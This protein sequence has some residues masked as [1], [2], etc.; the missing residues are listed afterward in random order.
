E[1][2]PLAVGRTMGCSDL[3]ADLSA[4]MVVGVLA[5]ADCKATNTAKDKAVTLPIMPFIDGLL[6]ALT[7]LQDTPRAYSQTAIQV[8]VD[9]LKTVL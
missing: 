6:P 1:V 9:L 5:W 4:K 7:L 8:C 2:M 3:S